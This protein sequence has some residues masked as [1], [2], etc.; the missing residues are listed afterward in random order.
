MSKLSLFSFFSVAMAMGLAIPAG[1]TTITLTAGMFSTQA[2]AV[3]TSFDSGT[4][5]ASFTATGTNQGVVTGSVLNTYLAPTGDT[6]PYAFVGA[7]SMLTD[8]FSSPVSYLG[9]YWGSADVY[10]TLS[11]TDINGV[12]TDYP[13]AMIPGLSLGSNTSAYVNFN[14]TTPIASVTFTSGAP[15]F[16]FDNLATVAAAVPE[17]VSIALLAGGF[18]AIGAGAF[19]RRRS[20]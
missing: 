18:L 6:T 10:N 15:A 11:V 17:P 14:F 2:G 3:N 8:T 16:E 19:R 13:A 4:L 12:T 9:L 20:A 5:P 1:A 7:S